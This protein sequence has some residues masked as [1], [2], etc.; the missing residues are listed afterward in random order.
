MGSTWVDVSEGKQSHFESDA[1]EAS[2]STLRKA[3][4]ETCVEKRASKWMREREGFFQCLG[5]SHAWNLSDPAIPR[6]KFHPPNFN[7]VVSPFQV[8]P[9]SEV[10]SFYSHCHGARVHPFS[11]GGVFSLSLWFRGG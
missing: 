10:L 4:S 5:S 7:G 2:H 11:F 8:S 6:R 1:G 3:R 9:F